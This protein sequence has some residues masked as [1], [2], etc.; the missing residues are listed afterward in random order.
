M[1]EGTKAETYPYL[2]SYNETWSQTWEIHHIL[3]DSTKE[4][5]QTRKGSGV[6]AI[7]NGWID[8]SDHMMV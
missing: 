3:H 2:G 8:N 6:E 7:L 4:L 1:E 5:E